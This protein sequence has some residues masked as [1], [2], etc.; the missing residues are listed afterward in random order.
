MQ[1]GLISGPVFYKFEKTSYHKDI[2]IKHKT[3]CANYRNLNVFQN[4]S[5]L[6]SL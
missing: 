6:M 1:Q 4:H 5:F 3:E 2:L